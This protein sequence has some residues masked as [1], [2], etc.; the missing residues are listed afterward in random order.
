MAKK[1]KIP[2]EMANGFKVRT[3]EELKENWDLEKVVLYYYDKGRLLA[4]LKD[5][6]HHN[7]AEQVTALN[8]ITDTKELQKRLCDIF[9]MPFEEGQTVD[10]EEVIRKNKRL[11]MLRTITAED[12][13]LKNAEKVALNQEELEKRLSENETEIILFNNTFNIPFN[14]KNVKYIGVGDVTCVIESKEYV[15]FEALGISFENVKFDEKYDKYAS[16]IRSVA[17]DKKEL[18]KDSL[19]PM[20]VDIFEGCDSN[21]IYRLGWQYEQGDGVE[22]NLATAIFFYKK[23]EKLGNQY[24]MARLNYLNEMFEKTGDAEQIFKIASSFEKGESVEQDIDYAKDLYKIAQKKGNVEAS[25]RLSLLSQNAVCAKKTINHSNTKSVSSEFE[26]IWSEVKNGNPDAMHELADVYAT[27]KYGEKVDPVLADYWYKQS[28]L[29]GEKWY[30]K[31][32]E[33]A[34][35]GDPDAMYNMGCVYEYG[36]YGKTINK[37]IAEN[38]YKQAAK[39]GNSYAMLRLNGMKTNSCN[40]V[41]SVGGVLKPIK[42]LFAG[43]TAEK[44]E[45]FIDRNKIYQDALQGNP[46]AMVTYAEKFATGKLA[47]YWYD[48]AEKTRKS[49]ND[50]CQNEDNTIVDSLLKDAENG[51]PVAMYKLGGI[52]E[53]GKFGVE[54]D[55][56]LACKWYE[57]AVSQ[58]YSAAQYKL[59]QN[60]LVNLLREAGAGDPVAMYNLG[61]LYED[62][63]NGVKCDLKTACKWY[64][65]AA[66]QGYSAAQYKLN[67]YGYVTTNS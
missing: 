29:A 42:D 67:K 2:L 45:Q 46:D 39:F 65:K 18:D 40:S 23:A 44:E 49:K 3:L 12:V 16:K 53:E 38:W 43:K 51:N 60:K 62:G 61:R 8:T 63:N 35:K 24:A 34:K 52:Y 9:A 5:Y 41:K 57:Q 48:R 54:K 19:A 50:K 47:K 55:F 32:F 36:K 27:G 10:V 20:Q 4:W 31:N 30:E 6:N 13:V 17:T 58:G 56:E 25:I 11:T 66:E 14:V 33:A 26:K 21:Q 7:E 28:E 15:D 22:I 64:K 59:N 1:I 37:Q